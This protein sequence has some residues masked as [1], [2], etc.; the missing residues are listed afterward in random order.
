MSIRTSN[1]QALTALIL[2]VFRL[3]GEMLRAGNELTKPFDLTSARWQILGAIDEE[4]QSLTVSQIARRM[5]LARQ[6]VQRI[7]NDLVAMGLLKRTSNV[8]HKSAPLCSL[9]PRGEEIIALVNVEQA[10]WVN[11]LSDG[12]SVKQ[13]NLCRELLQAIR[14]QSEK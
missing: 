9:S 11:A 10:K 5:G 14:E 1:G 7:V 4:G 6:G 13:L 3:N 12:H 2:E 8:D